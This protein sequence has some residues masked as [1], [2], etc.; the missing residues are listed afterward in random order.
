MGKY[1]LNFYKSIN[2]C[3]AV[4]MSEPNDCNR[5][6]GSATSMCKTLHRAA[7]RCM[8]IGEQWRNSWTGIAWCV[9][10]CSSLLRLNSRQAQTWSTM[11]VLTGA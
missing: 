5:S 6:F 3:S 4:N 7:R 1:C 10:R 9:L 11:R 2:L 8:G